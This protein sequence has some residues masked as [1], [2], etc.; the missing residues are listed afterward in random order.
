[1]ETTDVA[2]GD[3]LGFSVAP[4]ELN[5]GGTK[6][7]RSSSWSFNS[8]YDD[9]GLYNAVFPSSV[10]WKRPYRRLSGETQYKAELSPSNVLKTYVGY[11]L[12]NV[13]QHLAERDLSLREH[14]IY[15]NTV[16]KAALGRGCSVF[17]GVAN[18]LVFNRINGARKAGDV[19][20]H[21]Q[22]EVHLKATFS[23]TFS[24]SFRLLT[25]TEDYIRRFRILYRDSLQNS[26]ER[27]SLS[28]Y[29]YIRR[30]AVATCPELVCQSLG[31]DG[32]FHLRP[33]MEM[34][35]AL[36]CQ[37][38]YPSRTPFCI[39]VRSLLSVGR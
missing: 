23:K 17:A 39:D 12:T 8:L 9:M 1:M 19:Y 33:S 3:K 31:T 30:R 25:G 13:G 34:D 15:I 37:L 27:I 11:D 20:E 14:N 32:I 10:S 24:N 7:F 22:N 16:Y 18:S 29:F 6:A 4:I 35:A 28:D 5:F 26:S 21:D 38:Y 2:T 36:V